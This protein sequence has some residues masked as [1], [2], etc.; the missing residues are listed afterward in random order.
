M[1]PVRVLRAF[2]LSMIAA[3]TALALSGCMGRSGPVAAVQ[4][5][6]DLDALAYRQQGYGQRSYAPSQVGYFQPP[7]AY[8]GPAPETYERQY[9]LD[10]GDKL[11]VVVY[12]QEGLSNSYAIYASGS[13]TMPLVRALPVH[14]PTPARL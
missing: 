6:N 5:Q 14:C 13:I 4:P 8:A 2:R 3:M 9:L 10:A 12:G 7:G 11:R 1:G